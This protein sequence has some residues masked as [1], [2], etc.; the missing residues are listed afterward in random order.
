MSLA[1]SSLVG[2]GGGDGVPAAAAS[3]RLALFIEE[4]CSEVGLGGEEREEEGG[5]V[6]VGR[7]GGTGGM[8][9]SPSPLPPPPP[10]PPTNGGD[11]AAADEPPPYFSLRACARA[12]ASPIDPEGVSR[13]GMA[14]K[15]QTHTKQEQEQER[16]F[17]G[18]RPGPSE[19]EE[20]ADA[21]KAARPR[22]RAGGRKERYDGV[23]SHSVPRSVRRT[24]LKW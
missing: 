23:R 16:G 11:E 12:R 22:E 3:R 18:R 24:I 14:S 1:G 15:K 17:D 4:F 13:A 8:V 7:G 6:A 2:C 20:G 19:G 5:L 9:S 10:P 21:K